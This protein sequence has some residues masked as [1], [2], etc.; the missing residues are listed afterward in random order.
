MQTENTRLKIN[1]YIHIRGVFRIQLNIYDGAFL[2][3][4]STVFS[5]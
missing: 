3:K 5:R 1:K 4:Q 2:E